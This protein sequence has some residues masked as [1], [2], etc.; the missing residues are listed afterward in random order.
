MKVIRNFTALM[1][2]LLK[3]KVDVVML[4]LWAALSVFFF[5]KGTQYG[6]SDLEVL[7]K[8]GEWMDYAGAGIGFFWLYGFT[9]ILRLAW[10][11]LTYEVEENE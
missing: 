3:D 5:V 9:S 10:Y 6:N 7:Q 4:L 8:A 2:I 11:K 1:K